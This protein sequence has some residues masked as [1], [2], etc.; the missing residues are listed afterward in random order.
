MLLESFS[1]LDQNETA[2]GR[3]LV[4]MH[5]IQFKHDLRD[6]RIE[7]GSAYATNTI[8]ADGQILVVAADRVGEVEND[9]RVGCFD[10]RLHGR[11][12]R[13]FD[14]QVLSFLRWNHATQRSGHLR[15]LRSSARYKEQQGSEVLLG[16]THDG[17]RHLATSLAAGVA[18]IAVDAVVDIA[19]NVIVLEVIRIVVAVAS[20]A[21][22]N[23]VVGGVRMARGAHVIGVAVV[24]RELGVLPVIERGTRPCRRVVAGLAGGGEELRLRRV[25][26]I[27]RVVVIGLV[28]ANASGWQGGVV[29]V[30][31]TIA[32][33]PWRDRV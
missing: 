32:A 6:G 20:R 24:C 30:D 25:S 5:S 19:W 3:H 23:G 22:E 18:L 15:A 31:V 12:Q 9:A 16:L 7:L 29:V 10:G 21:L 13:D 8:E 17:A 1:H 27:G 14:A 4:V 26:G 11:A 2:L 28:A 33:L